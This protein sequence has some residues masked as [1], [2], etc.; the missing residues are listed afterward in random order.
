M[1]RLL[2]FAAVVSLAV[3]V[4]HARTSRLERDLKKR[5]GSVP[6][7]LREQKKQVTTLPPHRQVIPWV[8]RA[9]VNAVRRAEGLFEVAWAGVTI[10]KA[11]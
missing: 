7:A 6:A 3:G 4:C 2:S 11:P 9:N 5:E 8:A 10:V 1:G